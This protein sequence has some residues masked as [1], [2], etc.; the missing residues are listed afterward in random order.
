[1]QN[2]LV[3]NKKK[4]KKCPRRTACCFTSNFEW[5]RCVAVTQNN[6]TF[7]QWAELQQL[8]THVAITSRGD[9]LRQPHRKRKQIGTCTAAHALFDMAF[10]TSLK[11][12]ADVQF[13]TST[14]VLWSAIFGNVSVHFDGSS[15]AL[16]TAAFLSESMRVYAFREVWGHW[17]W[18]TKN[19]K[20]G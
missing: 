6:P 19:G 14:W 18:N 1:M 7:L 8:D 12:H 16:T 4:K 15:S 20:P 11:S 3:Y 13:V 5:S 17:A 2:K 9:L 10:V